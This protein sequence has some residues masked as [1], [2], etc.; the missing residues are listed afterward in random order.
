MQTGVAVGLPIWERSRNNRIAALSGCAPLQAGIDATVPR[1]LLKRRFFRKHTGLHLQALWQGALL[2]D[3]KPGW[4]KLCQRALSFQH[5]L[6]DCPF[7]ASKF[8]E[9]PHLSKARERFPWPSLW[10]RG[11]VPKEATQLHT[12]SAQKGFVFEGLWKDHNSVISDGTLV[13]ASDASGGPGAKDPRSSCVAWAIAAYRL[14]EGVP[15]RVASVTCFPEKPLTVAS[16]EQQ[17]VFVLRA[18]LMSPLTFKR[19]RTS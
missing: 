18:I 8:P 6:W 15:Q 1:R 17:A 12:N 4:C 13:Y 7:T 5:V 3:S 2:S 14:A 16:A 11:L 10:L 19:L 9:P